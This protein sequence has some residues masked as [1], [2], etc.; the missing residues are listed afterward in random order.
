MSHRYDV[1]YD[2]PCIR[3]RRSCL[4]HP[5]RFP[6]LSRACQGLFK[7]DPLRLKSG[8]DP[9]QMRPCSNP[10]RPLLRV[11][12]YVCLSSLPSKSGCSGLLIHTRSRG[13]RFRPPL[14][15]LHGGLFVGLL[16]GSSTTVVLRRCGIPLH[17]LTLEKRS[18]IRVRHKI[19][20][21]ENGVG[22][23]LGKACSA[24]IAGSDGVRRSHEHAGNVGDQVLGNLWHRW[25]CRTNRSQRRRNRV[26]HGIGQVSHVGSVAVEF[27]LQ[28][29]RHF[30]DSV[31]RFI[32]PG[33]VVL[34]LTRW[35]VACTKLLPWPIG[36]GDPD[37]DVPLG[38]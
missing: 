12:S 6:M 2:I 32:L 15:P 7:C 26:V 17:K 20:V 4:R 9:V 10:M 34:L 33:F 11:V 35:R 29:F 14:P 36:N 1:A 27:P 5:M 25:E 37:D 3:H 19:Q 38:I 31:R 18:E 28:N 24:G 16:P 8:P 23:C 21:L 22:V 30:C 13:H